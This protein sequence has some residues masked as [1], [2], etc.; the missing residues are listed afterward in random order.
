M[1]AF[2]KQKSNGPIM[3]FWLNI[4]SML[5]PTSPSSSTKGNQIYHNNITYNTITIPVRKM[6]T[7]DDFWRHWGLVSPDTVIKQSGSSSKRILGW[8]IMPLAKL[9]L[10]QQ[11][12]DHTLVSLHKEIVNTLRPRHNGRHLADDVLKWNFLN[13][14]VWIPIK[15]SLKFVTKGQIDYIPAL[16]QIIAWRRPG[17]KPL[18]EPMMVRLSTHI[19]VTRPQWDNNTHVAKRS[20]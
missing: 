9:Q 16:V 5:L 14:N 10:E 11:Q 12:T 8:A 7:R 18:S 20:N 13:E 15:I 2:Q 17:D 6:I 4:E 19:C 1:D 3:E